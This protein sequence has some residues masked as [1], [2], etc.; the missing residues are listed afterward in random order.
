MSEVFKKFIVE[1]AAVFFLITGC[2]GTSVVVNQ[3]NNKI[4]MP[5]Y[6]IELP[7]N[8][9]WS[10]TNLNKNDETLTLN[11]KVNSLFCQMVFLRNMLTAQNMK[12]L[13]AKQVA[14]DYRESEKANMMVRGVMT[15]AY[16]LRDVIMGEE[17]V[18]N[19]KF[20]CCYL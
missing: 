8:Q 3:E 14:D 11:K 5:H 4:V 2:A 16:E 17:F 10:L 7:A 13:N 18:G 12:S 6:S 19:K 15:G 20:L 9:G 1:L